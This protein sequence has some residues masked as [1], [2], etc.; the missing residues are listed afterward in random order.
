VTGVQ[1]CALPIYRITYDE[2]SNTFY[3]TDNTTL[4]NADK[5][6]NIPSIKPTMI[7]AH[8]LKD[9]IGSFVTNV[10]VKCE[11]NNNYATMISVGA[12][13]NGNVVGEDA[14]AFSRWNEG[15]TDRVI[16]DRSS[17][18]DE[19]NQQESGSKSPDQVYLDNL[20]KYGEL[21]NAINSGY[22]T[23]DDITNNGQAVVDMLKY[24]VAYFTQTDCMQGQG[25]LPINL[26]LTMLGLSGPRLF[27]TYTIDETLLPDNYKNNIKFLTKGITHKVDS[28]GW[29]T[30]LDSF[31]A[32]KVDSL[33]KPTFFVPPLSERQTN[34]SS[35]GGGAGG[36]RTHDIVGN[37][38]RPIDQMRPA[39][40]AAVRSQTGLVVVREGMTENLT[41]GTLWYK[42][43][44]IAY[45]VEDILRKNKVAGATAIG[46]NVSPTP[47]NLSFIT[48]A[49]REWAAK[50]SDLPKLQMALVKNAG[51]SDI[52]DPRGGTLNYNGVFIHGGSNEVDSKGCLLVS[53]TRKSNGSGK[54]TYDTDFVKATTRYLFDEGIKT[55]FYVNDFDFDY[56]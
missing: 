52:K 40:Q 16:T 5:Y 39:T 42:Q 33:K 38:S 48:P 6:F 25:F 54:I 14:T 43:Q 26:Q 2:L 51:W 53:G 17:I 19:T 31:M 4:P 23:T 44:A 10:S 29:M 27:E 3:I 30:T 12:Q 56:T 49:T 28:N 34:E 41:Y 47:Y 55:N 22:I 9:T 20:I 37:Q 50:Y 21:N 35:G 36:T 7:N 32:P 45:T 18:V 11:L 13:S 8:V 24:E 46:S 1:T 15:Y